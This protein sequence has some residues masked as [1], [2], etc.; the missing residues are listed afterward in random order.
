MINRL[1]ILA[2]VAFP[3]AAQAAEPADQND[4][5]E[6]R[7]GEKV[8]DLPAEGYTGFTCA[9]QPTQK[10]DAW[11]DY[12]KCPAD[13]AGYRDISFRYDDSLNPRLRLGLGNGGTKVAGQPV[14]LTLLIG[15]DTRVMALRMQTDP[16]V[17]LFVHKKQFLFADQIK[18]H[19][20]QDG[21]TCVDDKAKDGQEPIGTAFIHQHCS[22]TAGDRKLSLEQ[23]LYR[24]AGHSGADF[25]SSTIFT[26]SLA[27]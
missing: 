13:K 19:Y 24:E 11:A 1:A 22:K 27:G 9:D 12:T 3:I 5:R 6:F 23:A 4:L 25:I 10:L 2:L 21:W 14:L 16:S 20:G 8:A 17:R 15:P 7:V 18:A 26:I